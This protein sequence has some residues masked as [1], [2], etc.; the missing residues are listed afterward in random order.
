[1]VT[2]NDILSESLSKYLRA[3][4]KGK[5]E[6]I[7]HISYITQ[8]HRKSVIRKLSKLQVKEQL[9]GVQEKLNPMVLKEEIDKRVERL[10]SL[11]RSFGNLQI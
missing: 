7:E 3:D 8:M 6:I 4:K 10:Y 5:T 2:K 9:K 1:M 11:Q